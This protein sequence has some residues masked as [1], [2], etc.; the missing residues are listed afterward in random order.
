[1][2]FDVVLVPGSPFFELHGPF[3]L[4]AINLGFSFDLGP[5]SVGDH[6]S[7]VSDGSLDVVL[8]P[9]SFKVV[10]QIEV[11]DLLSSH[12]SQNE[13]QFI[14]PPLMTV[15]STLVVSH[16]IELEVVSLVLSLGT[17]PVVS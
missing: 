13:E 3:L 16:V 2:P 7:P 5:M 17:S 11:M 1:M 15:L 6:V 8:S 12:S 10:S 4:E 9:L 14:Q